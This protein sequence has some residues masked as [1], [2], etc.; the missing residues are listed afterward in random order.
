MLEELGQKVDSM[1]WSIPLGEQLNGMATLMETVI[2][3][4]SGY[5][6]DTTA[7]KRYK[8]LLQD[9]KWFEHSEYKKQTKLSDSQM[10]E[11]NGWIAEI[12]TMMGM[13]CEEYLTIHTIIP[14]AMLYNPSR[15]ILSDIVYAWMFIVKRLSNI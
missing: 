7:K 12:N 15:K 13:P 1:L 8:A 14:N 9:I 4:E 5:M 10:S 6:P 3:M 11:Y 2:G